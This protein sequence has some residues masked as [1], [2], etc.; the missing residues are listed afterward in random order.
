MNEKKLIGARIKAAR[1]RLDLTQQALADKIPGFIFSRLSNYETGY[2]EPDLETLRKLAR[3]L[4]CS[5]A[6]LIGDEDSLL[7]PD[8]KALL[9]KY[10]NSNRSGKDTIQS[11]AH[12]SAP[13]AGADC[14][15]PTRKAS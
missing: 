5:V 10:R 1:E 7:S 13:S 12:L 11:V 9:Y 3:A 4:D 2:R 8:E 14:D 15:E 6:Y